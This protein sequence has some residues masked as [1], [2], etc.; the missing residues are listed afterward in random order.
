MLALLLP[1][2]LNM[3]RK[4]VLLAGLGAFV[5]AGAQSGDDVVRKDT[6]SIHTIERG[7]MPIFA[8]ATGKLTSQQPARAVLTFD[9]ND[10]KCEEGRPAR[11]DVGEYPTAMSGK[12]IGGTAAAGHC[13]VEFLDALPDGAVIGVKVGA[14]V[15]S[16]ELKDVVFFG[17]PAGSKP[18]STA[19][20]FV[21]E[22][23]SHARRV[24]VRY[25]EMSGPLIQVLGG[26]TP[27][28]KVIVTDMSKWAH[29]SRVR[30]E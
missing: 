29:L 20:I 15:V 25:G 6:I 4:L 9:K 27:G 26:L 5:S 16:R 7:A 24:T 19:T 14:L 18:N 13:E 30:L 1:V 8:S 28:D 17:R 21:I 22:G 2:V 10:G 11:L 3:K 12:V 23:T